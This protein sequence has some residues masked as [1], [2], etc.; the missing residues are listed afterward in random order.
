MTKCLVG[1][2][3]LRLEFN[4]FILSQP[5]Q[6][7]HRCEDDQFIV[8]GGKVNFHESQYIKAIS[9]N[10]E[11]ETACPKKKFHFLFSRSG[12]KSGNNKW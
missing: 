2:C 3:Q 5:E 4:N 9:F 6:E 8:S 11:V 12:D 1:V 7:N 10:Y